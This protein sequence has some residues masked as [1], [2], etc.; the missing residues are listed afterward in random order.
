MHALIE[1]IIQKMPIDKL[2]HVIYKTSNK[3]LVQ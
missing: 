3:I 1:V 2:S